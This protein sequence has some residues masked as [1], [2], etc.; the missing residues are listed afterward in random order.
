MKKTKYMLFHN[1]QRNIL[2]DSEYAYLTENPSLIK[3]DNCSIE[4]VNEFNFLG[5]LIYENLSWVPHIKLQKL[6]E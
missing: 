4:Q 6:L 2:N 1:T 5:L 3:I